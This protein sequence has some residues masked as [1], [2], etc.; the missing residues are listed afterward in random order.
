MSE[1]SAS[2]MDRHGKGNRMRVEGA[3]KARSKPQH[4]RC[5]GRTNGLIVDASCAYGIINSRMCRQIMKDFGS[6]GGRGK[7]GNEVGS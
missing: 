4:W 1:L 2:L 6:C 7:S 5:H 3:E